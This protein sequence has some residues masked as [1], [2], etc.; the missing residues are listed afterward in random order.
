M[1]MGQEAGVRK[2]RDRKVR[3]C[4]ANAKESFLVWD[5]RLGYRLDW[6]SDRLH[7]DLH[8]LIPRATDRRFDPNS[9]RTKCG[10]NASSC[11][12][13][14]HECCILRTSRLEFRPKPIRRNLSFSEVNAMFLLRNRGLRIPF[15]RMGAKGAVGLAPELQHC[16]TGCPC[17][18]ASVSP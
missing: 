1:C 7:V 12:M 5:A 15:Q 11:N 4:N 3:R 9:I 16:S 14:F 6:I 13:K 2:R 18:G 10:V 17:T 8:N